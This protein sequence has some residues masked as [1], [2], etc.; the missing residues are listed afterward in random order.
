MMMTP[1]RIVVALL[2]L[3]GLGMTPCRALPP[4]D[5]GGSPLSAEAEIYAG[6]ITG[7][8]V[9]AAFRSIT[10]ADY[11]AR[12]SFGLLRAFGFSLDYTFSN[13]T[14]SFSAAT[15]QIGSLPS[16][17]AIMRTGNLNMFSGNADFYLAQNQS[18]KFY[19]SPGVGFAQTAG[20]NLTVVTPLGAASAPILAGRTVTFNMG[21]GLK[22]YPTK[23]FGLRF[24]VRDYVWPARSDTLNP[25]EDLVIAGTTVSNPQQYFGRIPVQNNLVFTVGLI[26]RF[27]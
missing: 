8:S 12:L 5:G 16:G 21:A 4:P 18:V 26:F 17:S 2:I 25:S 24:D 23:H 14:R 27:F 3:G 11:G 9:G 19:I 13:Q 20:R 15:P 22:V 7:D 10:S 6:G 1:S